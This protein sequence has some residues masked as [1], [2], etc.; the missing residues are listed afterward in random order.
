MLS[1]L[2]I[3]FISLLVLVYMLY[4]GRE[5]RDAAQVSISALAGLWVVLNLLPKTPV[6]HENPLV[7]PATGRKYLP[8]S[9]PEPGDP[10]YVGV[11]TSP[12]C[13]IGS[14]GCGSS[15]PE[16]AHVEASTDKQEFHW[17]AR[18]RIIQKFEHGSDGINIALPV[19]TP[20]KAVEDGIVA[21]SDN[22]L[23]GYGN[24]ILIRHPNGYVSSYAHNSVLEVKVGDK[25]TRG[26]TI[27]LSGQSGNVG[28]PQLHFELRKGTSPLNPSDYL[29]RS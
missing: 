19:G 9:I 23:K 22:K 28:S 29:T 13:G 10:R 11:D 21:Y 24:M 8:T 27:V 18:G 4:G 5:H 20:V 1:V 15:R 3:C 17:P 25:V 2:L 16:T 7:D 14:S 12:T 26:Q 6:S